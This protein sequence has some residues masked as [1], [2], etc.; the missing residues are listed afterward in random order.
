MVWS[1]PS[2]L[3]TEALCEPNKDG[4]TLL[5]NGQQGESL[6]TKTHW[7]EEMIRSTSERLVRPLF[8]LRK[9]I[10]ASRDSKHLFCCLNSQDILA[11]RQT[12]MEFFVSNDTKQNN[13]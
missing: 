6:K 11:P 8:A 3:G 13:K 1:L 4:M 5:P 12:L 9:L 2:A 10:I 7:L